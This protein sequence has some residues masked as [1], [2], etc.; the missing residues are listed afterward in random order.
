MNTT[1]SVFNK[2]FAE[3]KT[4]LN[5]QRV[6]LGLTDNL[7]KALAKHIKSR[8]SLDDSLDKWYNDLFKLRDKFGAF[9]AKNKEFTSSL[10]DMK[11]YIKEADK[12]AKA[13]GINTKFLS[14]YQ[15]AKALINTSSD[16]TESMKSAR[17]MANKIG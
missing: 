3:K 1:K 13:L 2:V 14:G 17:R 11:K 8:K 15:D 16:M 9:E 7:E 10:S 12:L 6:E 4:E 5:T